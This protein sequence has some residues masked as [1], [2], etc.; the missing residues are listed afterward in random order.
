M[1]PTESQVTRRAD[2]M[3]LIR[4]CPYEMTESHE[5]QPLMF[6][7]G[8]ALS[9][10]VSDQGMLLLMPQPA[11]VQQVFEVLAATPA[12]EQPSPH[13]V[14]VRW[15]KQV[16]ADE[17]GSLCLAGVRFLAAPSRPQLAGSVG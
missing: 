1:G 8:T 4:P 7:E 5:G 11:Q 13:V 3:L 14:E 17:E 9:V 6:H 15:T 10:N 2:R 16:V 12:E